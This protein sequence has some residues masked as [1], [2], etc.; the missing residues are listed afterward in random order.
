MKIVP[1][2]L[3]ENQKDLKE[4]IAVSESFCDYAQIDIMDGK[5]VPSRSVQ[6]ADFAGLQTSL[7][8]EIHL[9]VKDPLNYIADFKTIGAS[10]IIFHF[11]SENEP[12][13]VIKKIKDLKIQPGLALNPE[14]PVSAAQ[15]FFGA[16]DTIL[17]MTV[18]PGFYGSKFIPECLKKVREIKRSGFSG[19]AGVDGGINKESLSQVL[20]IGL[21]YVCV[22]SAIF[23][24]SNPGEAFIRLSRIAH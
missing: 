14:T 20:N 9:M 18:N 17:V 21:D 6:A 3:T 4:K 19:E 24:Q 22:G 15:K 13:E 12:A 10:R 1:A 23:G 7:K 16:L 5:F 8:I 2:I 11:E